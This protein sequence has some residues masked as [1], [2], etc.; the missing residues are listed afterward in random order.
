MQGLPESAMELR[1]R[2][3]NLSIYLSIYMWISF[4]LAARTQQL[5]LV[6]KH[7]CISRVEQAQLIY[8]FVHYHYNYPY[9]DLY[10][11]VISIV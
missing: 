2:P 1:K 6:D 3:C 9:K 11:L 8:T 4:N 5:S 10:I 7:N